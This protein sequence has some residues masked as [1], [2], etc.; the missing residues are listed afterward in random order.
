MTS[1]NHHRFNNRFPRGLLPLVLPGKH[2]CENHCLYSLLVH[3]LL[4][5]HPPNMER[6]HTSLPGKNHLLLVIFICH[7]IS[8][9]YIVLKKFADNQSSRHSRRVYTD[10]AYSGTQ[11]P[12]LSASQ[13]VSQ[14]PRSHNC[15]TRDSANKK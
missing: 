4:S 12:R 8:Y 14:S 3:S 1:C 9:P 7:T 6:Y 13:N 2:T 10:V 11:F 5:V 15:K